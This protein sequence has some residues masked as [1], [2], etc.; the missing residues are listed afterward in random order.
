MPLDYAAERDM[1]IC[2]PSLSSSHGGGS[3]LSVSSS[4]RTRL[5]TASSLSF[6]HR[7]SAKGSP[8]FV[9]TLQGSGFLPCPALD[10]HYELLGVGLLSRQMGNKEEV[11]GSLHTHK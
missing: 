6:Q 1:L 2:S 3:R 7:W 8:H 4:S 10:S 9:P 11:M 5:H